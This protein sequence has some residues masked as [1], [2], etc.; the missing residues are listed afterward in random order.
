MRNLIAF[1]RAR[2]ETVIKRLKS[3]GWCTQI[4]RGSR[5]LIHQCFDITAIMTALEIRQD[6]EIDGAVMFEV[7]GPWPH[8]FY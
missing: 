4:F 3:H 6:F 7:V 5:E 8:R 2:I 1:Y